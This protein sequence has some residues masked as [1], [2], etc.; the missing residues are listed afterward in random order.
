[1]SIDAGRLLSMLIIC[2]SC[3]SRTTTKCGHCISV[4]SSSG[5]ET[6]W[7]SGGL[8][9]LH[10]K[11]QRE[12]RAV[13]PVPPVT[14]MYWRFWCPQWSGMMV[15]ELNFMAN[16]Y[17]RWGIADIE[18]RRQKIFMMDKLVM[19]YINQD[20]HNLDDCKECHWSDHWSDWW[21]R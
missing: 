1:M 21:S 10:C 2:C 17:C 14:Y 6:E 16:T 7:T 4:W 5:A 20:Y 18:E 9:G 3:R 19:W 8:W 11:N 13:I 12:N 15:K